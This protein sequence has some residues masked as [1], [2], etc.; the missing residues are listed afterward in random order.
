VLA[1]TYGD[2]ELL[3]LDDA[4]TD[5]SAEILAA[6][7]DPPR[8][9]VVRN[10][11]NSGSAFRQW[12]R[13]VA[14][15]R[16]A[17]VWLAESDDWAEP[18]FLARLV[19]VLDAHPG[20]GLAHCQFHVVDE[21][22]REFRDGAAWWDEIDAGRWRRDFV[23]PGRDELRWMGHWNV[24][25]NAS[26]VLFRRD[27]YLRVGGADETMRLAAD[28]VLW[29]HMLSVADVAFVATPLSWWRWHASSMR[30]RAA[31]DGTERR[32]VSRALRTFADATGASARDVEAAYHLRKASGAL[33]AR[34][35]LLARR[36]ALAGLAHAPTDVAAWAVGFR[37]LALSGRRLLRA[38]RDAAAGRTR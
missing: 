27:V 12:N 34:D 6:H 36:H 11:E 33:R 25:S 26:A 21:G 30:E 29:I 14:L 32:D 9:R 7:E 10:A 22:G 15:A 3:L 17:Y 38:A 4:S 28:W 24:I 35:P 8:V 13:G 2:W 37:A 18:E 23:A 31:Q 1:Q 19:A 20:V 16:G 5:G